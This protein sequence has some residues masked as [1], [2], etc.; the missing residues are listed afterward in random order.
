LL[1][2]LRRLLAQRS[3]APRPGEQQGPRWRTRRSSLSASSRRF[4]YAILRC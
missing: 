3:D 1:L 4:P 2:V